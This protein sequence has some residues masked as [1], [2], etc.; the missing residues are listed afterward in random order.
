MKLLRCNV[1]ERETEKTEHNFCVKC[2]G[3]YTFT[4][5]LERENAEYIIIIGFLYMNFV[6]CNKR[7]RL[8]VARTYCLC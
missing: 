2:L 3:T 8:R 5:K 4:S 1:R 6:R 7:E